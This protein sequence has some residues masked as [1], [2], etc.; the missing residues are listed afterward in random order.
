MHLSELWA[1][2]P[3]LFGNPTEDRFPLLIKIIDA[4]AD[5]SIQVHPDDEYA[6]K[7]ENGSLGK[8]ECWYVLDCPENASLVI[9]HNASTREELKE[10]IEQKSID[11]IT[12][13]AKPVGE[14]VRSVN[15]HLL[16]K[17]D[18]FIAPADCRSLDFE[19][20]MQIIASTR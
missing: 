11:V 9:G 14:S 15:G 3:E 4:K 7:N 8:T 10:M 16:K 12:V 20:N 2:H 13:P 17:G 19:G 1:K 6:L 5:L 18:H